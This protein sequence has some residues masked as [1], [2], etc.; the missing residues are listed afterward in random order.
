MKKLRETITI[1]LVV[2]FAISSCGIL[3]S[4]NSKIAEFE[5]EKEI[6]TIGEDITTNLVNRSSNKISVL[7]TPC[8]GE[9]QKKINGNWVSLDDNCA[10]ITNW[11]YHTIAN[12]DSLNVRFS[13][14]I[15]SYLEDDKTGIYRAGITFFAGDD[16]K[17]EIFVTSKSFQI[18]Q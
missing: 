5:L 10:D 12:N 13:S 3:N 17:N 11:S 1:I 16:F 8:P 6:Y 7:V 4:D 18:Q 9:L 14:E 15:I 2:A